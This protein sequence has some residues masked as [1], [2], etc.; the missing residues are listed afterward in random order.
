M[1]MIIPYLSLCLSLQ[2]CVGGGVLKTH[3]QTVPNPKIP[4]GAYAASLYSHDM[5][6]TSNAVLYTSAWLQAH[7][8]KPASVSHLGGA[9]QDEIWTYRFGPIWEGIMPIVVIPIPIALPVG[10]ETVRFVLRDGRVIGA[11]Q[12]R[13]QAAGGAVGVRF[14]PCGGSFGAFSLEGFCE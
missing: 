2:G 12:S 7:W 13:Q 1:K 14:G 5:S 9:V 4:D 3:T 11:T 6:K 8:G 10:R